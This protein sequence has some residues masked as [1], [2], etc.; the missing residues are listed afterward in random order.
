M[1][2]RV[3][4]GPIARWLDRARKRV[5]FPVRFERYL[6]IPYTTVPTSLSVTV[7]KS[8]VLQYANSSKRITDL[9]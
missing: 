9:R 3:F 6:T 8:N 1:T 2:V 7:S 5:S 4:L